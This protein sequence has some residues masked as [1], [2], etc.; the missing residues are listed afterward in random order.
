MAKNFGLDHQDLFHQAIFRYLRSIQLNSPFRPS[1]RGLFDIQTLYHISM[2]CDYLPDPHLYRAIFLTAFYGFLRMSNCAPHAGRLFDLFKHFLRQDAIFQPPGV[3]LI[4]KWTKTMQD[5][6]YDVVQ[7]PFIDNILLCPVMALQALLRSRPLHPTAPLFTNRD[8][9]FA[10][11]I[12]TH[13]RDAL[14]FVLRSRN[15]PTSG[16][17]F[18]TF[19]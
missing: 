11:V 18:H 2:A 13:I 19:R 8:P 1:P 5:K 14:R 17:G 10:Q 16:H 12:D 4:L 7:L 15:I 6:S 3:H 9:P